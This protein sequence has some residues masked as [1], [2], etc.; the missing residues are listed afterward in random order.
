[1]KYHSLSYWSIVDVTGRIFDRLIWRQTGM[2]SP[3][4]W[5]KQPDKKKNKEL[6][7]C[8]VC[9]QTAQNRFSTRFAAKLY[10]FVTLSTVS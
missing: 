7:E 2:K 5:H 9:T 6:L 1:M 3:F 8:L 10:V 4:K